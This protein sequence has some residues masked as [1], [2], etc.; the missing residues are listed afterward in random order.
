MDA[1]GPGIGRPAPSQLSSD[2]VV[3]GDDAGA[4]KS[5]RHPTVPADLLRSK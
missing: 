1:H 4:D 2:R 3:H 5:G